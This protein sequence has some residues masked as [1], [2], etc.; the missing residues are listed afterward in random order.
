MSILNIIWLSLLFNFCI[1]H[2]NT[3]NTKCQCVV[4]PIPSIGH[5][6]SKCVAN[7]SSKILGPAG[8]IDLTADTGQEWY[9]AYKDKS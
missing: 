7:T 2:S 6:K 9:D 3:V 4:S 5:E 8:D 1:I